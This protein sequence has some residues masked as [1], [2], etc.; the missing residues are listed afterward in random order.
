MKLAK[1]KLKLELK[2][3]TLQQLA[4]QELTEAAGGLPTRRIGTCNETD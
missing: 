1:H 3:E 4:E 2:R